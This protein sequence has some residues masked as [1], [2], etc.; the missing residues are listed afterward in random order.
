MKTSSK[1]EKSC[2]SCNRVIVGESKMGLCSVCKN[3]YG[4]V[5]VVVG[6]AVLTVGLRCVS[7]N[8]DKIIKVLANAIKRR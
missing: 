1:D 4:T 5:V 8:S 7:K 3:K 6:G 2:R